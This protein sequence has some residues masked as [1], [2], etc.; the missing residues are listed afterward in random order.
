[1]TSL[2]VGDRVNVMIANASV[3]STALGTVT[4]RLPAGTYIQVLQGEPGVTITP[5]THAA[6]ALAE[7]EVDLS[8]LPATVDPTH[9]ERDWDDSW[10]AQ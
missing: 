1:M 9:A 4:L 8:W 6:R 5:A 7:P 3:Q 2:Q 10:S